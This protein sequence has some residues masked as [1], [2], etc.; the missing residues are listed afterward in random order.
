MLRGSH[1]H[2][3][4]GDP[5]PV[6]AS[7]TA[8]LPCARTAAFQAAAKPRC[9]RSLRRALATDSSW[10]H[11]SSYMTLYFA[12]QLEGIGRFREAENLTDQSVA[13]SPYEEPRVNGR[14]IALELEHPGD[15]D[16]ELPAIMARARRY[17]PTIMKKRWGYRFALYRG[18]MGTAEALL[19]DPATG[20]MVATG[21][22][23]DV[24]NAVLR[25]VKTKGAPEIAAARARCFP[26]RPNGTRPIRHSRHVSSG[27]SCLAVATPRS[28]LRARAT[29]TSRVF[30]STSSRMPGCRGAGYSIPGWT[31]SEA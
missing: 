1:C 17:W 21:V 28:S 23:K 11:L 18:D 16:N 24:M 2:P 14:I 13:Q 26:P 7:F 3:R 29:A 8:G 6:R 20:D 22:S 9:D 19:N 15:A 25:A 12:G 31:C 5:A 30:L 10:P 4:P 27:W